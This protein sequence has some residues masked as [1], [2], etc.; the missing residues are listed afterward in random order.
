M[1]NLKFSS[2]PFKN[3]KT[4]KINFNNVFYLTQYIQNILF[5]HVIVEEIVFTTSLGLSMGSGGC[6]LIDNRLT[7]EKVYYTCV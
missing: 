1:Y 6:E 2:N 3:L 7:G 5:Q 4:G